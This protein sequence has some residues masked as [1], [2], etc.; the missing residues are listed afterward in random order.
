MMI[1]ETAKSQ[2]AG[3]AVEVK[4]KIVLKMAWALVEAGHKLSL[5]LSGG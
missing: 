1:G 2:K 3:E 4:G 5:T